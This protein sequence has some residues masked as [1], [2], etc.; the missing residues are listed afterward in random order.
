MP[1]FSYTARNSEGTLVHGTLDAETPQAAHAALRGMEMSV[2]DLT[3]LPLSPAPQWNAIEE[4]LPPAPA[5]P[6]AA[7][8]EPAAPAGRDPNYYPLV[9]TLRLYAGWLLAWYFAIFAVGF[10]QETNRLPFKISLIEQLFFSSTV[11][12]FAC[13]SFLFL[14]FSNLHRTFGRGWIRGILLTLAGFAVFVLFRANM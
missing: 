13:A 11:L 6:V 7:V 10:Y 8:V 4:D 5:A 2:E 14:L 12:S 1:D 9:D 3:Q